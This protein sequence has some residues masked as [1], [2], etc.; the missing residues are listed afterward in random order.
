MSLGEY[1]LRWSGVLLGLP[2]SFIIMFDFFHIIFYLFYLP[3]NIRCF[4]LKLRIHEGGLEGLI[5]SSTRPSRA[6]TRQVSL[7]E[8]SA[9]VLPAPPAFLE[10][11]EKGGKGPLGITCRLWSTLH[12]SH[13][14]SISAPKYARVPRAH[15]LVSL[16]GKQSS[17]LVLW[18]S[19]GVN[20]RVRCS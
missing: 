4:L 10:L 6:V 19:G 12:F 14:A 15:F 16:S 2:F 5:D 9:P 17:L 1:Q 18:G 13:L 20:H 8:G 11:L 3:P 7:C